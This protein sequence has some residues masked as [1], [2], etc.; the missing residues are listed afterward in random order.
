MV[1]GVF[2]GILPS[3]ENDDLFLPT[4]TTIFNKTLE[5]YERLYSGIG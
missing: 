1:R 5:R 4:K 3:S 2:R